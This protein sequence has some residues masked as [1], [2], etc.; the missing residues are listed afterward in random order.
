VKNG[1]NSSGLHFVEDHTVTLP[2]TVSILY[3]WFPVIQFTMMFQKGIAIVS[4]KAVPIIALILVSMYS[5]NARAQTSLAELY[6]SGEV[7]FVPEITITDADLPEMP[8]SLMMS[9]W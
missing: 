6:R 8:T 7:R 2:Y 4:S 9:T 5:A 3:F 1:I